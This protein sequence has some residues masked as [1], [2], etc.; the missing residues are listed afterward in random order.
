MGKHFRR[1]E[2][3]WRRGAGV[4]EDV[5][6]VALNDISWHRSYTESA[7]S[8]SPARRHPLLGYGYG[9]DYGCVADGMLSELIPQGTR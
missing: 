3:S 4:R 6:D 1:T 7:F 9:Y 5:E 8:R 2:R